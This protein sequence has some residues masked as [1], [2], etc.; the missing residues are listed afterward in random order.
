MKTIRIKERG[1][2]LIIFA[3]AA[4]GLFAMVGLA[5]DASAQF[6]DRRHSQNAADTAALAGALAK[7]QTVESG[8]ST[9]AAI[10][11]MTNSARDRA[12]A[13]GYDGNLVTN[14]VSVHNPPVSGIYSNC[15]DVHFTC[16]DYVQVIIDSTVNTTFSRVIGVDQ[17]HN[18][19]EAVAST[20]SQNN[21]FNFGG[22]AIVALSPDGCGIVA[23]GNTYAVINGGGLFSNSDDPSC[24]F[25]KQSCAGVL[26]VNNTNGTQG[27]VTS[28]GG[29]S[30]N[31]GCLPEADLVTG[32]KQIS[33]PPP[34]QEISEP[35]ECSIPGK[36]FTGNPTSV[37]LT[38]GY[39]NTIPPK[40]NMSNVTL[41]PGVYC[42]GSTLKAN[43]GDVLKVSGTFTATPGVFLYFK[44]GGY[45][46]FNGGATVRLWG[47]NQENINLDPSLGA[48][49]N[50][51][52]YL[53]PNY[54]SGTPVQC[55]ING[56]SGDAFWG[57]IYAPY[58]DVK[59][60]GTSDSSSFQSQII[61]YTVDLTGASNVT[62]NYIADDNVTW[63]IPLQVGLSK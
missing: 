2:A 59:L 37:T 30:V 18:H 51:L 36:N 14:I 40:P 29:Y 39:Y 12:K 31:T 50:F 17:L 58:C 22:N 57:T 6:S 25:K 42:I 46:T 55:T 9:V 32:S 3:I 45:F 35:P 16:T 26:D 8:G 21:N 47:I 60:N 48:Y 28:V 33:F 44:P 54:A 56:N 38:P 27:A 49:K 7:L 41:E 11:A 63:V 1:Q 61:G 53:A 43:S 10:A 15:Y 4:I 5:I 62:L 52:M 20:V 19:V 24:S 13:N 34:Y 23:G